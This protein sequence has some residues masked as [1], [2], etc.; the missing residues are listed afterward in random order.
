MKSPKEQGEVALMTAQNLQ[1]KPLMGTQPDSA[2][3]VRERESNHLSGSETGE[4]WSCLSRD[5]HGALN[6]PKQ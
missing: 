2:G 5:L 3:P 4:T 6:K 1:V